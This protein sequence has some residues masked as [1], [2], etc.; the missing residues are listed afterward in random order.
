MTFAARWL[1]RRGCVAEGMIETSKSVSKI[2]QTPLGSLYED[3]AAILL[4]GQSTQV[5]T[6]WGQRWQAELR[7][8]RK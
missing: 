8:A 7:L 2:E 3:E 1:R 6:E 4:M 5:E